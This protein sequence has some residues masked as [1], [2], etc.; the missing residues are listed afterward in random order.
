MIHLHTVI[1]QAA[2]LK[3]HMYI[4]IFS[5]RFFLAIN[6]CKEVSALSGW[7]LERFFTFLVVFCVV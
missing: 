6:M 3:Y 7:I 1:N 5:N 4:T 2:G